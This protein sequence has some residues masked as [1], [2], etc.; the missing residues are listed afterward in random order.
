[1]LPAPERPE[2]GRR[3]RLI[4]SIRREHALPVLPLPRSIYRQ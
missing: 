4:V 2:F 3:V 1:M